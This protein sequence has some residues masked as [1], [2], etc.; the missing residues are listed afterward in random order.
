MAKTIVGLFDTTQ[1]AQSVVQDLVNSG[2]QRNTISLVANNATGTNETGSTQDH[3]SGENAAKGAGAGAVTGGLVGGGVGLV[4]SLLGAVAVPVVGPI[5]AAGPIVAILTGAGVGAAAGGLLGALTGAGVPEEDAHYYAEGVNR[6]G[7]LV[8]VN[9]PD[10]QA[11]TAYDIMQRHG[12]VDIDERGAEYK[13][14]GWTGYNANPQ[15][16]QPRTQTTTTKT[17]S[18]TQPQ[19]R[20]TSDQGEAVLPVMQEELQVGKRE[21]QRGG[22]RVYSHVTEQPVQEQV[23]LREEQ[24]NVERRPV[25]RAVSQSDMAAFKEGSFEVTETDEEAIVSKQAR[26]VEE[27]AINKNVQQRTETIKDT[28][29]RTDVDVEQLGTQSRGQTMGFEGYDNDFRQHFQTTYGR[30]GGN[31]SYAQYT[32]VYRYGYDLSQDKR[33]TGSDWSKVEPEARKQWETSNP[34]N[35]WEKVKDSVRYAWDKATNT[36]GN[37]VN[38]VSQSNQ[39]RM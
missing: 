25:N 22:V 26:V 18:T 27:V 3:S 33:Y 15:T 5:I 20:Q 13:K 6:G 4:L 8:M 7:T 37:T 32:P 28:V 31:L 21:V 39:D 35:P 23:Q 34:N 38:N 9:S 11:D 16:A 19:T 1:E 36:V 2:F 29:R 30:S 17:T 24:V 12:A 14:S 10:E